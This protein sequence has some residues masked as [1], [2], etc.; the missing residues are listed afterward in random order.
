M[1]HV[2]V[3]HENSADINVHYED[4]GTGVPVVLSHG[5]PLSGQAWEKQEAALLEPVTA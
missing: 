5:Y 4:H 3:G 2:K 1:P